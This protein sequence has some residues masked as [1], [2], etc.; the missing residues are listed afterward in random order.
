MIRNAITDVAGVRVGHASDAAL[1]SGVTTILFDEAVIASVAIG[2]GAPGTR[3]TALLEPGMSVERVDA[4]VLSGGSAFGLDAMGGVLSVLRAL[5]R[6]FSVR[7]VNV[8][9]VPGAILFD[10]ANG[11]DKA[12][13]DAPVYWHLGRA[14]AI[15]ASQDAATLDVA[16]G[17][18]GAGLGATTATLK[19]GLGTASCVT[20]GG[21]T[22]GAIVAVNA[23]GAATIGAG[24]HFWAAPYERNGEFGGRGWPDPWPADAIACPTK[25]AREPEQGKLEQGGPVAGNTTVAVIAT[26]AALTRDQAKRLALMAQDG[27][28]KAL[29]PTHA[30]LDGDTVFAA[31]TARV[32]RL[33]DAGDLVVL[34]TLAADCLARA[35]ARGIYDATALPFT[36]ALPSWRDRFA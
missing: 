4:L 22:V 19:G 5:G 25:G 1:A 16:T 35:I 36:G 31:A 12:W 2:G 20:P 32:D 28:A 30:A 34:G 15:A 21:F 3:D 26:D 14:A 24:P 11:G 10:L 17:S 13:G 33:P 8:P 6:G 18:I 9:I 23:L 7:D 27:L 29:R